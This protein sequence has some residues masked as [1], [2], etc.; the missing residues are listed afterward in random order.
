MATYEFKSLDEIA[1]FFSD[2]ST[3]ENDKAHSARLVRDANLA[4]A[5]CA[6]FAEVARTL[7]DSVIN[8]V[9]DLGIK[10][11]VRAINPSSLQMTFEDMAVQCM[12][13]VGND[14]RYISPFVQ[15]AWIGYVIENAKMAAAFGIEP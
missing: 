9:V 5:R 6:A 13:S 12:L 2:K 8:P 4:S 10:S 11:E 15:C 3:Q 1:Q 7:R 14:E